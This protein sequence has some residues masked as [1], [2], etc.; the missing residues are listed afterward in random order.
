MVKLIVGVM[1]LLL[2]A[3]WL[4]MAAP[5]MV[6][7]VGNSADGQDRLHQAPR[8]LAFDWF[9]EMFSVVFAGS[10]AG[11]CGAA[12]WYLAQWIALGPVLSAVIVAMVVA[13]VLPFGL[14]GT[15]LEGTPVGVISPRLLRSFW[16]CKGA[17]LLFYAQTLVLAAVVGSAAWL[18]ASLVSPD[19]AGVTIFLW[20][21][22]PLLI[23]ALL[24]DMRLLG[25]LAWWISERMPAEEEEEKVP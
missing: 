23:A 20:C 14:L 7:I 19:A 25:R 1:G 6:A 11:L 13:F 12:L 8:L 21:L 22:G 4:A 24:L 5:L 9:S 17:W 2:A 3:T 15:L 10:L 18:V 16:R